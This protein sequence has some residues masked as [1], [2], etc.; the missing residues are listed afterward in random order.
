M[1]QDAID[2]L[3]ETV[4]EIKAKASPCKTKEVGIIGADRIGE[5]CNK[6][7]DKITVTLRENYNLDKDIAEHLMRNYGT[8]A[9]QVAEIEQNGFLDRKHSDHPRRLHSKYPYLEAEIVFAVRQEYA[10]KATDILGRR[11]RLAFIDSGVG[12]ELMPRVVHMMGELLGWSK[13]RRD[14][15]LAECK[16]Y[17]EAMHN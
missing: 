15:E 16:E 14:Q 5:V 13:A 12:M 2:K 1:A 9:L 6:K 3:V 4:P 8:R 7:F 10:L 11:M 17:L